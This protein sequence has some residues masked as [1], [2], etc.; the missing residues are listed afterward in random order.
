MSFFG[1][2]DHMVS[3]DGDHPSKPI[4]I[5]PF[6]AYPETADRVET[7]ICNLDAYDDR[8]APRIQRDWDSSLFRAAPLHPNY[9]TN[10][11]H[12]ARFGIF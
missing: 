7:V 3:C 11:A 2:I 6:S 4:K 1:E 12:R 5:D 8:V 10:H 9:R